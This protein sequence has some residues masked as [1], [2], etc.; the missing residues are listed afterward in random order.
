ML[1]GWPSTSILALTVPAVTSVGD[2]GEVGLGLRKTAGVGDR[3]APEELPHAAASSATRTAASDSVF[4][5]IPSIAPRRAGTP[6]YTANSGSGT[7]ED[8][9]RTARAG[10][11]A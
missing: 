10:G 6:S 8:S 4:R 9:P 3:T 7:E 2:G 11:P 1:S 5:S